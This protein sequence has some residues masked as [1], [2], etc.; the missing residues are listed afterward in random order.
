MSDMSNA[1]AILM[2]ERCRE[3]IHR[4]RVEIDHLR[5]K[6]DAY[7]SIATILRLLP[8]PSQP[9]REDIMWVISKRITELTR[10]TH[11]DEADTPKPKKEPVT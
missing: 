11:S 2:L 7:D 1:E 5:P 8:R 9:S 6:A 4:L 10:L 3:E